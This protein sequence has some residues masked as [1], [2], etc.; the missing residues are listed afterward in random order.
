[1]IPR[2]QRAGRQAVPSS[3]FAERAGSGPAPAAKSCMGWV[4]VRRCAYT[5]LSSRSLLRGFPQS[6]LPHAARRA[7]AHRS[8]I[9]GPGKRALCHSSSLSIQVTVPKT[10][11]LCD[12]GP[13]SGAPMSLMDSRRCGELVLTYCVLRWTGQRELICSITCAR[14]TAYCRAAGCRVVPAMVSS[15]LL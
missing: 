7:A 5:L 9:Q 1:M 12:S 10:F 11:T 6:C 15:F 4:Y 13:C 3:Q 14:F 8:A 2:I